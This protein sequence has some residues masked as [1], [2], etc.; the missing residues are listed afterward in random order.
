MLP[1]LLLA[2]LGGQP[3]PVLPFPPGETKTINI[4]QWDANAL[5]KVFQRSDQLPLTEE[6]VAKLSRAGFEPAQLV[7]MLEERRCACDASAD[8]LI[9][10]KAAGAHKDVLQAVSTHALPPNRALGLE[11]RLDFQGE[12]SE[13]RE[14]FL[15]FFVDDG[16]LTRA[17]TANLSELLSRRNAHEALVDRSDLLLSKKVRRIELA[18][19][20]P[21][22]AYGRH[23][24]MVVASASP[25]ITHP[26][27]LPEAERKRALSYTFEYP[28]SSLQSVCRLNAAYKRDAML[29]HKWHFQGSRFECEWN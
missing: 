24:V 9:R 6:E 16:E 28:R 4:I 2:L 29:A 1:V 3:L 19:Q 10:L 5:P 12:G 25:T 22:K 17:F 20:V 27:Q 14:G 15:Y 13:A 18:G 11:V 8:G 7:K 26:S 23:Q 21:L